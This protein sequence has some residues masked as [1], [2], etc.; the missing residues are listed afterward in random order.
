M[1]RKGTNL[2]RDEERDLEMDVEDIGEQG[3]EEGGGASGGASQSALKFSGLG[4]R[5]P[6]KGDKDELLFSH[7]TRLEILHCP[8]KGSQGKL[9]EERVLRAYK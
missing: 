1:K 4:G 8:L 5:S 2:G 9:V 7:E 3:V 6:E